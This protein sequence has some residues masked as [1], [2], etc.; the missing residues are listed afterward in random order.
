MKTLVLGCKGQLGQSLAGTVPE[1]TDIIGLDLPELDITDAAAVTAI[2]RQYSPD[3]IVN[4]AAYTAVEQAESEPEIATSINVEGV[5]NI[6]AASR[7]VDARFIHISTDFV[8]DG[9]STTP[10]KSDAVTNPLNVY[11]Q[12]KRDGE[13]AALEETS[14]AA[15]IIRTSWLYS[16][17]GTNFVTIMLRLMAERD[18]LSVVADQFGTPTWADSLADAVWAFAQTPENNGVFHWSDGGVTSWHGFATKVQE[19]ALSLG[20]LKK[21]IP[22][23]AISA[24]DYPTAAKRPLYG[25]LDCSSTHDAIGI[26]PARW[27]ANLHQMLIR[28]LAVPNETVRT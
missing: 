28:K 12:T 3:V 20:L 19:E 4:A 16:T 13:L 6:A 18:E 7:D 21:Q 11:G 17:T 26:R 14:G 24:K 27:E 5:R 8:F 23:H 25:V 2:C 1:D 10:Y 15:I 22:I 9:E